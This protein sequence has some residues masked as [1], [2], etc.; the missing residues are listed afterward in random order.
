MEYC[1]EFCIRI[2]IDKMYPMRLSNDTWDWVF[3]AV[4]ILKKVT[5][6]KWLIID[7]GFAE[8]QIL[9]KWKWLS[10][11]L[12]YTPQWH[13]IRS[14]WDL[15]LVKDNILKWLLPEA[16][17]E[18]SV[19]SKDL[20]AACESFNS[21]NEINRKLKKK[22]QAFTFKRTQFQ[23]VPVVSTQ[24]RF[25]PESFRP[26]IVSALNRFGPESFRP[27]SFR[28]NLVDRSGLIFSKSPRER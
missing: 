11:E 7:R 1:D 6:A 8:R 18:N 19:E 25:G 27:E 3:A 28:P 21:G 9:K 5:I 14:I 20:S 16:K 4:Q 13:F 2:D 26:W 22:Q 10:L 23:E 12:L 24:S 15:F 17:R